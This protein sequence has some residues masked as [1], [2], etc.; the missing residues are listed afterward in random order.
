M[1]A[2]RRAHAEADARWA[3]TAP[4]DSE[5]VWAVLADELDPTRTAP[6]DHLAARLAHGP[7]PAHFTRD[8]LLHLLDLITD[9]G[10]NPIGMPAMIATARRLAVGAAA[11][12]VLDDALDDLAGEEP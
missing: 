5:L 6:S 7:A 12:N 10:D 11:D 9:Y 1:E 3:E 4:D 2:Q 8:L